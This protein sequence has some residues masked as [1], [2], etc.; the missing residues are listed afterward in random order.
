MNVGEEVTQ[1]LMLLRGLRLLCDTNFTRPWL[2]MLALGLGHPN[3]QRGDRQ[4]M[5]TVSTGATAH[6]ALDRRLAPAAQHQSAFIYDSLAIGAFS[7]GAC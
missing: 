2:G 1:P 6:P 7:L 3:D 5:R 4:S